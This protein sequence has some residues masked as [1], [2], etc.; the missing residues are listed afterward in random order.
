MSEETQCENDEMLEHSDYPDFNEGTFI[1]HF[2]VGEEQAS[3]EMAK[4]VNIP[5]SKTYYV[6]IRS[7]EEMTPHF[8]VFDK[9]GERKG[10]G[11]I[12]GFHTCV[13]IERN[14]YFK[15]DAYSD[16][17]D[18]GVREALDRFMRTIRTKEEHAS[19]CGVSNY[20]HTIQ[21]WNDNNSECGKPNWLDPDREQPDYTTILN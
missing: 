17:L 1:G 21:A 11:P 3:T 6:Y 5:G 19:D 14:R 13:E 9:I 12:A 7:N 20:V 15:H 10:M 4:M 16:D 2:M 18:R 8:H